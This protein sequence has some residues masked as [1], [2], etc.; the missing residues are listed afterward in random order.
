LTNRFKALLGADLRKGDIAWVQSG[1]SGHW[2]L[3]TASLPSDAPR[4]R[5]DS[6]L[7]LRYTAAILHISSDAAALRAANQRIVGISV[8]LIGVI[9]AVAL[10]IGLVLVQRWQREQ[11]A[12]VL[13]TE[14]SR[15]VQEVAVAKRVEAELR[16]MAYTDSLTG[17]PNRAAFMDWVHGLLESGATG[18][19]A[20]F[21]IDLDRFN[22]VN[23]TIGHLGGDELLRALATRLWSGMPQGSSVARLGGDEFVVVSPVRE[24]VD[25]IAAAIRAQ[26]SEPVVVGGQT[27]RMQ[28][29][30]GIVIVDGSY[31]KAEDILRD[32]DI[33]VYSAKEQGRARSA[34]FD[35]AMRE[36]VARESELEADLSRAIE[37]EE[38]VVHYQP[39]IRV[40]T[41]EIA[42]FEAL[43]RWD[44]PGQDLVAA[45]EFIPFA[46]T[47]GL[48]ASIDAI[49]L[50][51]V[52]AQSAAIGALFPGA[53]IAA[54][55]SAVELASSHLPALLQGL[56]TEYRIQPE[57]LKLEI[58]ETAMMT[59]AD[60]A[61][62]TLDELK[63]IGT[64][65]VLDDFGTGY[66]SLAYLQR[67]PIS[68]LKIDRSFVEQLGHD[69]RALEVVRSIVALAMSFGLDTTAEGVETKAQL[70]ILAQLGVMYAQGYYFSK[71]VD[72]A[73]LGLLPSFAPG[74]SPIQRG[75]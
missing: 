31:G 18:G 1:V 27:L 15:L 33:A 7:P 67:L 16:V 53:P 69:D 46:E 49:M 8:L 14:Q 24:G 39:L 2:L 36:R 70:V 6:K 4:T 66:S 56:L 29:S 52:C 65:L 59:R 30:I 22:I 50:R 62:A 19:H 38:F 44:R 28:A 34:T 72:V 20:I 63:A 57:S 13:R 21:L 45:A 73:G 11:Q 17:L 74:S 41:G 64:A 58:T 26:I 40:E 60:A 32:A 12:T 61:A 47:H 51:T 43:I 54:N 75:G 9:L 35:T 42:S 5:I 25:K 3:G 71:A 23:E 55:I 10:A 37:R 68:G 48:I